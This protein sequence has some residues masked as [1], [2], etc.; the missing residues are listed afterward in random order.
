MDSP[1]TLVRQLLAMMLFVLA[2]CASE[3][4]GHKD[5]LDFLNDGATSRADVLVKLGEPVA[6][7]ESGLILA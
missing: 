3:P 4:V 5:L 7:Y 2:A 1:S 6:R